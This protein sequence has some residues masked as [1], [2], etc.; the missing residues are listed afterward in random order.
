MNV[1]AVPVV[2]SNPLVGSLFDLRRDR[3]GFFIRV[4][5]RFGDV[6]RARVGL[7]TLTLFSSTSLAHEVLVDKAE[8][9]EKGFGLSVFGRPLLGNGLLTSEG[10]F[11]RRQRKLLAPAFVHK[12]IAEYAN[13]IADRSEVAARRWRDGE[14]IDLSTET[15]RMTLEIVGKTLFD[16]EVGSEAAEIG[17]ALTTAMEQMIRSMNSLIPLPPS[18]PTPRNRIAKKAVARLDETIYRMIR[19]RRAQ[20]GVDKGDFL[21]MLLVAQDEDD[22]SVMNDTQVRDEAMTLFLAGHETT[23]N[24]LAW[25]FYLLA[26]HPD[27]RARLEREVDRALGGRTPTLADLPALPFALAVFKEAMRLYP[28]AYFVTRRAI[29][30]VHVGGHRLAKGSLIGVNIV[31]MHHRPAYFPEPYRFDPDRFAPERE[32][33]IPRGAYLPFGAGP[34]V[35]IGNHFAMMEGHLAVAAL[36]QR[37][38]L[39]LPTGWRRV[40][41]EG[42]VTQRPRGGIAMRVTRREPAA[43]RVE[44]PT[45]AAAIA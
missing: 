20:G 13:V 40:E 22:K 28:P 35:C 30:D 11:H 24:A 37:V 38:R 39:D 41:P 2:P 18:V 33:E 16:A 7:T 45:A 42:L 25:T 26:Q 44:A 5:E 29:R 43:A 19:E 17:E 36:T 3:I 8:D 21:S 23:A 34:R 32:K 12:R 14:Q 4:A 1:S 15:M 27:V 9:F 6:A 31:G 10:S